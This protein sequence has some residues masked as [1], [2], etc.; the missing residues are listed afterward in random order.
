MNILLGTLAVL[1][2]LLLAAVLGIGAAEL[3]IAVQKD[4]ARCAAMAEKNPAPE[5]EMA[6]FSRRELSAITRKLMKQDARRVR[7]YGRP[8]G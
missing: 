2:L 6:G 5:L 8:R 3:D 1:L 4:K 7:I